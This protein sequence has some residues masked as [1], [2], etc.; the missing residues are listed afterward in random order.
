M[1]TQDEKTRLNEIVF[2]KVLHRLRKL[3][4]DPTKAYGFIDGIGALA[5][6]NM[7]ILNSIINGVYNEDRR[8]VPSDAEYYYIVLRSDIPVRKA[9][10]FL[11]LSQT[12]YYE[13]RATMPSMLIKPRFEP[14]Q[15]EQVIK[16]LEMV[17]TVY[18]IF[19]EG[20]VQK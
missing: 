5:N 17:Q 20:V 11:H 14:A 13:M 10:K 2:C 7:V 6:C 4:R 3:N 8:Y 18:N 15:Y 1:L 9:C 16:F 19:E 12:T